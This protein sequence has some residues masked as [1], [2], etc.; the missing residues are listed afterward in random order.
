MGVNTLAFRL[1]QHGTLFTLDADMAG[2][3]EDVPWELNRQWLD[4][5]A[6]S[7]TATIYFSRHSGQRAGSASGNSR[8]VSDCRLRRHGGKAS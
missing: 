4:V 1:P 8:G 6:R 5:L 3:T 7:G 2:I